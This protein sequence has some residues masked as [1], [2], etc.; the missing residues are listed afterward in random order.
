MTACSGAVEHNHAH[1]YTEADFHELNMTR[2]DDHDLSSGIQSNLVD[3]LT[4]LKN[5]TATLPNLC[6]RAGVSCVRRIWLVD[7]FTN[8]S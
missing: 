4:A 2:A 6:L 8:R 5:S 3:D 7:P 1:V